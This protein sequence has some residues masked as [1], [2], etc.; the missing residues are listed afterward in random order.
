MQTEQ[1][2]T[3]DCVRTSHVCPCTHYIPTISLTS[4]Y[5][6]CRFRRF[7]C[8]PHH[9]SFLPTLSFFSLSLPPSPPPSSSSPTFLGST[10][11]YCIYLHARLAK[12]IELLCGTGMSLLLGIVWV[13]SC[14]LSC[15]SSPLLPSTSSTPIDPQ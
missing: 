7:V 10:S 3:G 9:F 12:H 14:S 6:I 13:Y 8:C 5:S 4:T 15:F 2:K 1:Q 11:F